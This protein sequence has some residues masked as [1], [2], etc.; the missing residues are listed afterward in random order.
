[1]SL[2]IVEDNGPRTFA[3]TP[4]TARIVNDQKATV[5][6]LRNGMRVSVTL[7]DPTKVRQIKAWNAD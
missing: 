1:M 6:Q 4:L 5:G 2:T 3:I 7:E